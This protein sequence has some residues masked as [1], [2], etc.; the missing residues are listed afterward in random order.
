MIDNE[1]KI[2]L[3]KEIK[4]LSNC[5][6]RP[7]SNNDLCLQKK[8]ENIFVK[9]EDLYSEKDLSNNNNSQG[10]D[11][12]SCEK[13]NLNHNCNFPFFYDSQFLN[14]ERMNNTNYNVNDINEE[15]NLQK[16]QYIF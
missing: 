1:N 15:K 6:T 13:E 3:F 10:I 11:D 12:N 4:D 16:Y 9:D 14:E 5:V 2:D 8:P 7:C